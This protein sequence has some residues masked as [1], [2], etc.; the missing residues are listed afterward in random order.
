MSK[1][2]V[3]EEIVASAKRARV[4]SER[5]AELH[6]DRKDRW[7]EV[8]AE[9]LEA[10]RDI[11]LEANA[12]DLVAARALEIDPPLLGRLDLSPERWATMILGLRVVAA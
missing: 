12:R 6:R 1:A 5:L 7:L 9:Q 10:K 3:A 4:A 8:A 2:F 11:I